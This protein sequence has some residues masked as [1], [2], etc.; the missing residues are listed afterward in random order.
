MLSS[1]GLDCS[2]TGVG[3]FDL[4]ERLRFLLSLELCLPRGDLRGQVLMQL[5]N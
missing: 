5:F 2:K 4:S 1:N 3:F